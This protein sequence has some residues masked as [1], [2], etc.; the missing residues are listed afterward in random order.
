MTYYQVL[1]TALYWHDDINVPTV[2]AC[3][4]SQLFHTLPTQAIFRPP[5]SSV[6]NIMNG[7]Y[8]ST[9]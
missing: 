1:H 2:P 6:Y 7:S 9:P 5:V 8:T 4:R 3:K